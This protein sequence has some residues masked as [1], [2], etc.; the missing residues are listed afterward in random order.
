MIDTM[1]AYRNI[2]HENIDY[3]LHV[4]RHGSER[5]D[6]LVQLM[7]DVICSQSKSIRIDRGDFPTEVVKSRFLKLEYSHIEYVFWCLDKTTTKIHN[8][9]NYLLTALYNSP[10]TIDSYYRAAVSHDLYG[11]Q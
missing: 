1:E 9:R 10:T 5:I 11:G 8:I 2:I 6:E 7:L 4:E 3:A